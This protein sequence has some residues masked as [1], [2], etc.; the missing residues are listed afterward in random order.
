MLGI[1]SFD[2]RLSLLGITSSA[3]T[4]YSVNW[5][6]WSTGLPLL[7]LVRFA[8][9][10]RTESVLHTHEKWNKV[11]YTG[12]DRSFW[13]RKRRPKTVPPKG[14]PIMAFSRKKNNVVITG[15]TDVEGNPGAHTAA[16]QAR[17][18]FSRRGVL[19]PHYI[20][21][22]SKSALPDPHLPGTTLWETQWW[23]ALGW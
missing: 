18:P 7:E 11:E 9:W 1:S 23:L 3:T 2:E 12:L 5:N 16:V 8:K 4:H 14:A 10:L 17:P 13:K 15:K 6:K 20:H 19:N 21:L 22:E